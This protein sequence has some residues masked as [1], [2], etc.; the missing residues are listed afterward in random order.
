MV[1]FAIISLKRKK[2]EFMSGAWPC[3]AKSPGARTS[4]REK[5]HNAL[6]E[7]TFPTY[8]VQNMYSGLIL[9]TQG[10]RSNNWLLSPHL[11]TPVC[12]D[13][14]F[15]V[16]DDLCWVTAWPLS[17]SS[18]NGLPGA[19]FSTVQSHGCDRRNKD[20]GACRWKISSCRRPE[21]WSEK[22]AC[23]LG[24]RA[25]A[26]GSYLWGHCSECQSKHIWSLQ[27]TESEMQ[28]SEQHPVRWKT[29]FRT[30]FQ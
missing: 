29:F 6:E 5:W 1:P 9:E 15:I 4:R 30:T 14:R 19:E 24:S 12:R 8:S 17:E 21:G 18:L 16:P 23:V 20:R 27:L 25:Q 2:T 13:G 28:W 10:H 26:S 11:K 3:W 7:M 22:A